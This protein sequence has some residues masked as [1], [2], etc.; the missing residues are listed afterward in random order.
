MIENNY[1][2]LVITFI[3]VTCTIE[4]KIYVS[5]NNTPLDYSVKVI[6][7]HVASERGPEPHLER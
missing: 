2:K 6:Y 5:C 4:L 7:P 3:N 1:V